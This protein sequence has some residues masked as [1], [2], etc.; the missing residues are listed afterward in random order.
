MKGDPCMRP[1]TISS[2]LTP[3]SLSS[4]YASAATA[5]ELPWPPLPLI[6]EADSLS[7]AAYRVWDGRID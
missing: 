1:W 3:R 2:S 4:S 6:L 5:S 7:L